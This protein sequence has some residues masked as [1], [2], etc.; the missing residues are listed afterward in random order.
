M[1]VSRYLQEKLWKPMGM[2]ADGSWSLD[3]K[4]STFEKMES[5]VNARARDFGRFGMLF[6]REGSWEGEQLVSRGW[7]EESTRADATTDPALDYQYFWW[8]NTLNGEYRHF[9]ASGK[10]GQHIYVAPEKD[11]VIVR[12]GKEEGEQGYGYWISLF[13]DLATKLDTSVEG[14]R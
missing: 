10:Y 9:Y 4:K 6:A 12:L 7:V 1:S 8:L 2:E 5:G 3:S 14:S 13:D 11:L